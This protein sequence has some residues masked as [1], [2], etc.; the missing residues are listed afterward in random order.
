MNQLT[1]PVATSSCL[2]VIQVVYPLD[3][4]SPLFQLFRDRQLLLESAHFHGHHE[5]ATTFYLYC[6]I[7]KD[8]IPRTVQ[9]LERMEGVCDL[10]R[11]EAK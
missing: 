9:F 5:Q 7:E 11:L 2:F 4:F 8:R 1:A 10:Q 6:H 3:T